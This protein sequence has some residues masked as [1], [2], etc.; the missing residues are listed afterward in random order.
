[1]PEQQIWRHH[2]YVTVAVDHRRGH[3]V[4]AQPG[5]NADTLK[6]FFDELGP[7]RCTKLEAVTSDMSA[8]Y[9]K[10]VTERSPH[11]KLI[12][13]RFHVQRL[14]QDAIDEVRR[15]RL[16]RDACGPVAVARA[17]WSRTATGSRNS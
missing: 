12:F 11:A 9:I 2:E 1:M 7:E 13:D 14:A 6:A 4:W 8:A 15:D 16:G 17:G 10:A 3:V 5:K